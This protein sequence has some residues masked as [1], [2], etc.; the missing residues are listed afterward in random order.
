MTTTSTNPT[1]DY[2]SESLD[3]HTAHCGKIELALKVPLSDMR[4]LARAYTPGVA[5]V[6][7]AIHKDPSRLRQLSVSGN[8]VAVITDG[9]A[10]L[11]LG[12]IGA[13]AMPVMEGKAALFKM[14]GRLINMFS[15]PR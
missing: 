4:D 15:P 10:V 5:A 3:L 9:S 2:G 14:T 11:G 7:E 8:A 13:A 12:D 6:C 1:P